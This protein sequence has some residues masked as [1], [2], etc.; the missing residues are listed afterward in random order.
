MTS[1]SKA[2]DRGGRPVGR[3]YTLATSGT[4][5]TTLALHATSGFSTRI[6]SAF[7]IHKLLKSYFKCFVGFH[8]IKCN[9]AWLI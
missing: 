3:Y 4:I 9:V 5:A 8:T 6:D 1:L 2:G 7:V